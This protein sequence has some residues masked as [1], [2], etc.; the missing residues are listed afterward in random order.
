VALIKDKLNLARRYAEKKIKSK[1]GNSDDRSKNGEPFKFNLEMEALVPVVKGAVPAV[2]F[3]NNDVTIRNAMGIIKE[4]NLKGIIQANQGIQKYVDQLAADNIPVIWTGTT[5]IP[6]RWEKFDQYFRTASLFATKGILFSYATSGFG[7]SSHNVRIIPRP[8]AL[9]VAHGL[10]E[11]EAI[12]AL[13]INPAKILGV[14]HLV[15][16]LETGKVANVVIWTGSPI[17]MSSQVRT[18]IINGKII[19]MTS[20][21]TRLRDKFE[22]IVKERTENR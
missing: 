9:S 5:T 18:V 6:Q 16:S 17:Q 19:P 15:G 11:K 12:Q 21:Q 3:T 10:S 7:G 4:Y 2:F 22:K 1:K 8:A 13:T 14:D 20:V